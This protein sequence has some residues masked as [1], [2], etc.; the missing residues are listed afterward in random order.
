MTDTSN[1]ENPFGDLEGLDEGLVKS[2]LEQS[3]FS[4]TLDEIKP[5]GAA[6]ESSQEQESKSSQDEELGAPPAPG[7][8]LFKGDEEEE[9]VVTLSDGTKYPL[10]LVEEWAKQRQAPLP[11]APTIEPVAEEPVRPQL[12][13][14]QLTE[15][16]LE[17]AGPVGR[18]ALMILHAQAQEMAE[19]KKQVTQAQ[20]IQQSNAEVE[21]A[22]VLNA[23]Q[24]SFKSDYNL[25]DDLME[26]IA[27]SAVAEDVKRHMA[28]SNDPYEA[29]RYALTR[30]YWN[31]PEARQFEFERQHVAQQQAHVRKQ[32]LAGVSGGAGPSTR[33]A[34]VY[35]ESTP[36]GRH[37]AA[38]DLV[39]QA[40]YGDEQ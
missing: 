40:M 4:D 17:M 14:P 2:V 27:N 13:L 39:R 1:T 23:A 15:E 9:N 20:Q 22:K 3:G 30:S 8:P 10:A 26:K 19:L 31:L 36:E 24:S 35:D 32:K 11:P 33:G 34:P 38:V 6:E 28:Q 21:A 16:D 25:P 12:N 18:A 7:G 37:A 5:S 29:V